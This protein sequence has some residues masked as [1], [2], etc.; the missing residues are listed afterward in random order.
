M[1][2]PWEV[3]QQSGNPANPQQPRAPF[4]QTPTTGPRTGSNPWEIFTPKQVELDKIRSEESTLFGRGRAETVAGEIG[5][6][7]Q[8][9]TRQVISTAPALVA[10]GAAGLDYIPGVDTGQFAQDALAYSQQIAEGGAQRGV[11]SIESAYADGRI[12][13][14]VKLVSGITGEAVP[15]LLSVLSGAG[16]ARLLAG[17]LAAKAVPASTRAGILRSIPPE[18]LGGVAT[19]SGIETGATAQELYGATGEVRIAP[20]ITAGIAKGSLEAVFPLIAG[21]SLGLLGTEGMEFTERLLRTGGA[22]GFAQKVAGGVVTEGTT[23]ALQEEIDIQMRS[24]VDENYGRLSPEAMSRRYNAAF[25]GAVAGGTLTTGMELIRSKEPVDAAQRIV[26]NRVRAAAGDIPII[27]GQEVDQ[28]PTSSLTDVYRQ[29]SNGLD[30]TAGIAQSIENEALLQE[31]RPDQRGFYAPV[32]DG[33]DLT[34][35][36]QDQALN[37]L[38]VLKGKGYTKLDPTKVRWQDV[39]AAVEDLPDALDSGRVSYRRTGVEE[40]AQDSLLAAVKWR[41]AAR[42]ARSGE[43]QEQALQK[44]EAA[45]TKA[46]S[47]G[48]RVE[49]LADGRVVLQDARKAPQVT[50]QLETLASQVSEAGLSSTRVLSNGGKFH[51]F[52][53]GASGERVDLDRVDPRNLTSLPTTAFARRMLSNHEVARTLSL[54]RAAGMGIRFVAPRRS[55]QKAKLGRLRIERG[56]PFSGQKSNQH[57]LDFVDENGVLA[58]IWVTEE[59]NNKL[60]INSIMSTR[61]DAKGEIANT[62]GSKNI[63][64]VARALKGY[65]PNAQSVTGGRVSGARAVNF[66]LAEVTVKLEPFAQETQQE[67]EQGGELPSP[68]RQ[69]QL[70]RELANQMQSLTAGAKTFSSR[71]KGVVERFMSLVD[72]GLRIDVAPGSSEFALLTPVGQDV[73]STA[74]QSTETVTTRE[75]GR[76]TRKRPASVS[77]KVVFRDADT[78]SLFITQ[79]SNTMIQKALIGEADV[80]LGIGRKRTLGNS[81]LA[82]VL[83]NE[84][85]SIGVPMNYTIEIVG[86]N[87][88]DVGVTWDEAEITPPGAKKPSARVVVRI[89]PWFY[90]R[91][92]HGAKPLTR[93]QTNWVE[94]GF[95]F[96]NL[97]SVTDKNMSKVVRTPD[98]RETTIGEWLKGM[99]LEKDDSLILSYQGNHGNIPSIRVVKLKAWLAEIQ[100]KVDAGEMSPYATHTRA[101]DEFAK[102]RPGEDIAAP[103]YIPPKSEAGKIADRWGIDGTKMT[104]EETQ[105]AEF[106]A[107]FATSVAETIV[108]YEWGRTN[109]A[110]QEL[111]K[112]AWR[113]EMHLTKGL[114]REKQM[115]RTVP[116]PLLDRK[117][118]QIRGQKYQQYEF[119]EWVVNQVARRFT[120]PVK[121]INAVDKFFKRTGAAVFQ[122]IRRMYNK[123][124]K[125]LDPRRGEPHE[126]V[127]QW[128]DRLHLRG[129]IDQPAPF[130]DL[131]TRKQLQE[132][133]LKNQDALRD[134]GITNDVVMSPERAS[135]HQVK[136]LLK[137]LDKN[138]ATARTKL[139]G[140]LAVSDR[141]NTVM[142]WGLGIH[143]LAD[144]NPHIPGIGEYVSLT[145]AMENTA[146]SWATMADKRIRDAQ[147]LGKARLAKLWN[148]MDALD[149]MTYLD[150]EKLR[151]GEQKA[152]WPTADELLTLVRAHKLDKGAFDMYVSMRDDYLQFVS[153]LEQTSVQNAR[154]T[155]RDPDDLAERIAQIEGETAQIR[156]RPYF[157]H[158]RFGRYA[159]SV[160]DTKGNTVYFELFERQAD[161]AKRLPEI[162]KEFPLKDGHA[163]EEDYVS[164]RLWQWQGMPRY[165]LNSVVDALGLNEEGLSGQQK[166]DKRILEDLAFRALPTESFRKHMGRRKGTP[167]YSMDGMR[168]YGNYF[169][170]SARFMARMEF[171]QRLEDAIA[172]VRDSG[173]RVSRDKR[174]QIADFMT[175]HHQAQ[176]SPAG[177]WAE[178]RALGFMWYFAFAPAAAF[179]NMTQVPIVTV[180]YL[181]QKF[182]DLATLENITKAIGSNAQDVWQWLRGE[183]E[184]V[185]TPKQE[186]LEEAHFNRLIDDGYATELA[187]ISQG[188]TLQATIAGTGFGRGLRRFAQWGTL[189]FSLAERFNRTVTFRAAYDLAMQ[190]PQNPWIDKIM[191]ENKAEVDQLRIDRG[192]DERQLRS[193]MAGAEAVRRTQFEYGRWSRPKFME[194]AKGVL[195]MFKTY[196][197]NMLY[198]MFKSERGVQVRY[199]LLMLGIAGLMGMPGA[200]DASELAKWL[201][202]QMGVDF[203][204]ER[205]VRGLMVDWGADEAINPDIV[206]HGASRE[207]F[208]IPAVLNGLGV[209]APRLDL[210]GSLSMGKL[211]PGLKAGLNP[212]SSFYNDAVGDVVSEVAGPVF[213][214]PFAL[215]QS[216]LDTSLPA[217]DPK[218]WEKA[219]PR[220]I[221][222][223]SRASRFLAEGRERDRSGATVLEFDPNDVSEQM[224]ILL[225]AGLGFQ[226]TRLSQE[227]DYLT[228]QKEAQDY[229]RGQRQI[230]MSELWRAYRMG[231]AEGK[232]SAL[233]GIR[234]FNEDAPDKSLRISGKA[235]RQSLQTRRRNIQLKELDVP[236]EKYLRGVAQSVDLLFPE[237]INRQRVPAR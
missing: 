197:Q 172:T 138:N 140:L 226:P 105:Y 124:S 168:A 119:E 122:F 146:L 27:T 67:Y 84:V 217:E 64:D 143:Q 228:A 151:K 7:L 169:G 227:W 59:A 215:Y 9:G 159:L 18:V 80:T 65:F 231:D 61:P 170:R 224:E 182:G 8:R 33:Y 147:K 21:K 74:K 1:A 72:Q 23:E 235:I 230:L 39:G 63:R 149:R 28:L 225:G 30:A 2:N 153:Y 192:W 115:A 89:N 94:K 100:A 130:L 123:M 43:A 198:F 96:H 136:N 200:D 134:I 142:D 62:L 87:V 15:F 137:L 175:R 38:S 148:F 156:A 10:L 128:I 183:T 211:I 222:A 178:L 32:V 189:P 88:Q 25:A 205:M 223:L 155:L 194:G 108:A 12:M 216:L 125:D 145:R 229:W 219:M 49:P 47:L 17:R 98:G 24:F 199:M 66:K 212:G 218:R 107:D 144:L 152:R 165:A 133:I 37:D 190:Q 90:A 208:G 53:E 106:F 109:A 42:D 201:A 68:P 139:E 179:I 29:A 160:R 161:R 69:R 214:V 20:S 171:V 104:I 173:G 51:V 193:Y 45:Y 233:Q 118:E 70:L 6:G 209:P 92:T 52:E 73:L 85:K 82:E 141:Y 11:D 40:Q 99:K 58:N 112:T 93:N 129:I 79:L 207:G 237:R 36:S 95:G 86:P 132:S 184:V 166:K 117:L 54:G 158:M 195:F 3:F 121:T 150:P 210:S 81:Q 26:D 131:A 213:G 48:A 114:S 22:K 5:A 83:R 185:D 44:A 46:R 203:D 180:P 120:R 50:T 162:G 236:R 91:K 101:I 167:G 34:F 204:F 188:P 19:A 76:R 77:Q 111:V 191:Q 116:H 174:T 57:S 113:R 135:T 127:D 232:A 56:A 164:D 75:G 126:V 97:A 187:A 220:S 60:Y 71:D 78:E 31:A 154:E 221:K 13:D 35:G 102:A 206:L 177:D 181:S 186:A 196:L 202:R 4:T 234:R 16:G 55:V 110:E 163:F 41:N 157:P 176:M 14:W 103:K